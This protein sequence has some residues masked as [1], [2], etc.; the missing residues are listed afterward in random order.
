MF[1]KIGNL[2]REMRTPFR[3]GKS[4]QGALE[5]SNKKGALT[6]PPQETSSLQIPALGET[7]H[8][9]LEK[10]LRENTHWQEENDALLQKIM[11]SE[12]RYASLRF[13][14]WEVLEALKQ[15]EMSAGAILNENRALKGELPKLRDGLRIATGQEPPPLENEDQFEKLPDFPVSWKKRLGEGND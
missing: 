8:Q 14:Y 11:A 1:E 13:Q 7:D 12:S 6:P 9:R 10:V 3:T 4:Q 2:W 15:W 5:T